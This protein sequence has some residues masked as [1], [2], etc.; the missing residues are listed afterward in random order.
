MT[1]LSAA[2]L[3]SFALAA[4]LAG[5]A[6]PQFEVASIRV[7][8]EP[9]PAGAGVQITQRQA[10]FS[11]LSMKD[12]LGIAYGVRMHQIVGPDWLGTARFEIA[13]TMPETA[14]PN[15]IPAMMQALL[16]DRF[17]LRVHREPRDFPV[18]A[19]EVATG[20]LKLVLSDEAQLRAGAFTVSSSTTAGVTSVDLG[21]GASMTLGNNRFEAKRVTMAMLAD[22]LSRFVDRPVVNMTNV[23]GR[24]DVAFE[25]QPTDFMAMA[26]RS[27]I[28][29]G[30][31][32]P[33]QAQQVLD[34]SS[35]SAVGDALK[36]SGLSLNPRR[37]P[38]EMLVVDSIERTPTEN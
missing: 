16:E 33:P 20:G 12:Y 23:E 6:R 7:S 25:L 10:R 13:A 18:Y 28:A 9:R 19:L 22:T 37:G 29:S 36:A 14:P 11:S 32:L 27:S 1:R 5:Q 4:S 34:A 3:L 17:K 21:N 26:V 15:S 24:Y 38:V 2:V 8:P 30:V 31:P 35:P